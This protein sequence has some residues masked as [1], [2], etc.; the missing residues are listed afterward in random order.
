MKGVSDM[1]VFNGETKILLGL[2][3]IF[4]IGG[5][6]GLFIITKSYLILFSAIFVPPMIIAS[7]LLYGRWVGND[8][9]LHKT[10]HRST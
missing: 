4:F 7:L 9:A 10:K 5:G 6:V 2:L 8:L 3:F 1:Y